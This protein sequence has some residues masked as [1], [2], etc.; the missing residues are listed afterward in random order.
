[1]LACSVEVGLGLTGLR[2]E[3]KAG[4]L[5]HV[6]LGVKRVR[7]LVGPQAIAGVGQGPVGLVAGDRHDLDR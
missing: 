5:A 3:G 7:A 2:A 4:R 6:V 1:L